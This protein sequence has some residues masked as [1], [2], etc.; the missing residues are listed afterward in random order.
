LKSFIEYLL[1]IFRATTLNLNEVFS[2][3]KSLT[4]PQSKAGTISIAEGL[5][6]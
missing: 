5:R 2:F 4:Y 1:L 3:F 6:D